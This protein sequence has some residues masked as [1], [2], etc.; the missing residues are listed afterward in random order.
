MTATLNINSKIKII[1]NKNI[2]A[3]I[4]LDQSSCFEII[5]HNILLN[6]MKHIGFNSQTCELIK[7]F[8]ENRKLYVEI[9]SKTSDL[10]L[11]G[12]QSVFQ[13][14]VL[15]VIFYN[16][17][18]LDI[19]FVP[20]KNIHNSHYEYFLCGNPFLV[21][22]VDDLFAIIEGNSENIWSKIDDYIKTMNQ[23]YIANKLK[24]NIKKTQIMLAGSKNLKG[25]IEIEN[26]II[27]NKPNIKIL[28]TL[29]TEDLKFNSNATHGTNNLI[30]QL[31]R[32]SAAIIRIAKNFPLNFKI[33][34]IH[35]LLIGKIRFNI[36]TWGNLKVELKKQN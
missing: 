19:P 28:G 3:V 12:N 27:V 34:L 6:K 33:Q 13:G 18:T 2:A 8:L 1:D 30:T 15:S 10:L 9:N 31:K 22:Y 35:S 14:S 4:A 32:R 23:Y 24:I 21:S 5:D 26:N 36:Q 17:F 11:V 7:Q 29:Y 25:K 16:I 20:H